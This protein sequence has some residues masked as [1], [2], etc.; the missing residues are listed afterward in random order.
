MATAKRARKAVAS[1]QDASSGMGEPSTLSPDGLPSPGPAGGFAGHSVG[2]NSN[3]DPESI[4]PYLAFLLTK[5]IEAKPAGFDPVL[6]MSPHLFPF[7][8]EGVRRSVIRGRSA[9]FEGCGLGKTPQEFEWHRHTNH[10]T[11]RP[12]ILFTPLGVTKQFE[13]EAEKFGVT[14]V[15]VCGDS[16]DARGVDLVVTNYEKLHLFNAS[17]YS[18]VIIDESGI[19]K[20]FDGSTRKAI[21]DFAKP[22]PYRLAA[23][24]TPAPNDLVEI[25]NHAEWLDVMTGKEIISTFFAQDGNT[26]Q[27][28]R[29]K[30]HARDGF[31][32]WL[33]SWCT[34]IRKPSDI[35][36]S[37]DG[38]SL[39][40]LRIHRHVL[41][42]EPLPGY[43]L[44][45]EAK[46]LQ[47]QREA[48]R[49]SQPSRIQWVANL[50]KAEPD[51]QWV[52][53]CETNS[54]QDELE[55]IFKGQSVSLRGSTPDDERERNEES[56]RLGRVRIML[57][58]AKVSG[59]GLNW[60]HCRKTAFVSVSHSYEQQYQA[61]RRLYR[62]G[63]S[64]PVDVHLIASEAEGAI[65][66]N[67]SRKDDQASE[68]FDSLL[69]YMKMGVDGSKVRDTVPYEPKL[70]MILPRWLKSEVIS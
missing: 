31:W 42:S 7:Q 65:L 44:A 9:M 48:R 49:A 26:T 21:T 67:L 54:E 68:M 18:Q 38:Y 15:K 52:F 55:K 39:P 41:E 45:I 29:L 59:W 66:A 25:V 24:A 56:W 51:D 35:G 43:F 1:G 23:T 3:L 58:K 47:E 62:F 70:K 10:R 34:A 37:D 11:G 33:A 27:N 20:N 36:Y 8:A 4:D 17:D 30:N 69:P 53:W 13:R 50:A 40:D 6:P 2:S 28:W 63:Q 19:L 5:R 57:T 61:I 60:Q 12:T 32:R 22:I 64:N 16:E 46:S 14:G